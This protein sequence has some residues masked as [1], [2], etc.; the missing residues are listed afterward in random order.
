MLPRSTVPT[1]SEARAKFSDGTSCCNRHEVQGARN[2]HR[3]GWK[4]V[5]NLNRPIR[6]GRS[7]SSSGF[8]TDRGLYIW[9][10]DL[11][12]HGRAQDQNKS[13]GMTCGTKTRDV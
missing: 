9:V 1:A 10:L 6:I 4:S 12:G 8:T 7:K 11:A 2:Q 5:A 13:D 3:H